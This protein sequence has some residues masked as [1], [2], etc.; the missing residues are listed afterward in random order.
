MY[1]DIPIN[2]SV[3]PGNNQL[4]VIKD[5][6]AVRRSIRN[7]V[8]TDENERLFQPRIKCMIKKALF[9]PMGS[10]SADTIKSLIEEVIKNHERRANLL[11][12]LVRPDYQQQE[13]TVTIIFSM[14]NIP[15]AVHMEIQLKKVR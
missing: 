7:L 5:I 15:D 12:V 9:E 2:L 13:Y 8:M 1:S 3:N 6:S 14:I 4:A 11:D 10:E